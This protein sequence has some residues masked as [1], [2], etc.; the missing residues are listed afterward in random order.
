[1]HHGVARFKLFRGHVMICSTTALLDFCENRRTNWQPN[2]LQLRRSSVSRGN[3]VTFPT[4]SAPCGNHFC[5]DSSSDFFSRN[6]FL[7][8]SPAALVP[9]L[10]CYTGYPI[11]DWHIDCMHNSSRRVADPR[12]VGHGYRRGVRGG[13][14]TTAGTRPTAGERCCSIPVNLACELCDLK[15]ASPACLAHHGF[16]L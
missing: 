5:C 4:Q 1:M 8:L 9:N 11:E 10:P 14:S 16:Y 15:T 13:W 3:E 12:V 7:R 2:L 6:D